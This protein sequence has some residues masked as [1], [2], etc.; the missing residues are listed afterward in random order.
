MTVIV[1]T[2]SDRASL[3]AVRSLGRAGIAVAVAD[4][5]RPSLSMWS[6]YAK[7]SFLTKDPVINSRKYVEHLV[8]EIK[9]RYA[10]CVLVSSDEEWWALSRH[11]ELLPESI[12]RNLPPHY[13]VIRALDNES[14]YQFAKS[15][16]IEC[17][18][19]GVDKNSKTI[20][21]FGIADR[22]RVIT[23]GF[24]EYLNKINESKSV[25]TL[26]R[27]IK[28]I[29]SIKKSS[30]TL[31][32]A[33]QWHGPF[34]IEFVKGQKKYRLLSLTGRLWGTLQLA[35]AS[36]VDIPLIYYNQIMS[37]ADSDLLCNIKKNVQMRWVIGD[38]IAKLKEPRSLVLCAKALIKNIKNNYGIWGKY[39]VFYDVLDLKDP[40]PFIF[41]LQNNT[42]KKAVSL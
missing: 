33:L 36:G 29:Y 18:S 32:H 4:R 3:A 16:G 22:G 37:T 27:T 24:Q 28:K 2:G 6:R 15:L 21:Y 42:W 41:D 20:S 30:S 34:K 26:A 23:E 12:S 7:S 38:A 9:S 11:R 1:A 5:K 17:S 8:K 40:M 31:L 35:I 10:T 13:S 25:I 39:E 19:I 14:L